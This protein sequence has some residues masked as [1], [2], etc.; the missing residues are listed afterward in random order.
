MR[1][2]AHPGMKRI[3]IRLLFGTLLLLSFASVLAAAPPPIKHVFIIVLENKGFDETFGPSAPPTWLAQTLVPHGQLLRQYYGT[4]HASLDN[5]VA[6][7]SGQGPNLIT[8]SDC[9]FYM[10][11]TP[12]VQTSYFGQTLGQGCVYPATAKTI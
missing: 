8:Q 12:G 9:T 4:G 6:M 5:Y 11:V 3:R 2:D 10:N 1:R 7:V